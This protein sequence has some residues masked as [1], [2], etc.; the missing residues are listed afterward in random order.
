LQQQIACSDRKRPLHTFA[1][2]DP[3]LLLLLSFSSRPH[4]RLTMASRL[5]RMWQPGSP[6]RRVFLPEWWMAALETPTHGRNRLPTN[7]V[8]FEV[9]PQMS[10]HDIREYLEKVYDAPVRSVRTEV[11]M[12]EILW[13]NKADLQYRKAMWKEED[14][15]FAYVFMKKEF[16]FEWPVMFSDNHEVEE[17]AKHK[18]EVDKVKENSVFAN[19]DRSGVGSMLS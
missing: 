1:Q 9:H 19:S 7:C 8:K 16:N 14:K 6:Q 10:K 2:L 3:S 18:K 5:A 17:I 11:Q 15:K 13:Q 12:G 4:P